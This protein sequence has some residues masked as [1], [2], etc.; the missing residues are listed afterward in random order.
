MIEPIDTVVYA[1]RVKDQN[2]LMSSSSGGAFTAIS[3]YFLSN[4]H[5][6]VASVYDYRDSIVEYRLILDKSLRDLAKG[7]KYIQSNPGNIYEEAYQWIKSN[8]DKLLLFVGMGC[9]AEGFRKYCELKGIRDK[10][11]IVDIICHGSPSPKLWKDYVDFYLKSGKITYLTFKDKRFGWKTPSAYVIM[12]GKERSIRDYVNVF[13]NGSALR[14]SCYECPYATTKRKIDMTIGD[15]WHIEKTIPEFYDKR[16]NSL[17][18]IHTSRGE[19]IFNIIKDTLDFKRSNTIQCWQDNLES[20]TKKP[21]SRDEFWS[22]YKEKGID[23]LIE[24]YGKTSWK[25]LLKEK[26]MKFIWRGT[27]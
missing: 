22:E 26:L 20:P 4:G 24:K 19:E 21:D 16:G 3:D 7:S 10:V 15:F 1:A 23:Y 8:P 27:K 11:Y 13:Y 2:V 9:Q 6:V 17:F 5:A 25:S 18:L 14:P 12:D